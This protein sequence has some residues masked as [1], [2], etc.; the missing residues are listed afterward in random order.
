ML[1][2]N[3]KNP[4]EWI[5]EL[6]KNCDCL[7]DMG[8]IISDEDLMMYILNNLPADHELQVEQM[9]GNINQYDNPLALKTFVQ[10]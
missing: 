3:T 7:E 8:S 10:R 5:M 6:E 2:K 4:E 9:E 1:K